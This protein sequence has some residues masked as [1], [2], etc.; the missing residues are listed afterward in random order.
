MPEELSPSEKENGPTVRPR[1]AQA[2]SASPCRGG[3]R[4]TEA[5]LVPVI[6]AS[7]AQRSAEEQ[8]ARRAHGR[9]HLVAGDG[10]EWS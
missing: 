2:L 7:R 6:R 10:R 3:A 9:P 5:P 8:A 1:P 4:R